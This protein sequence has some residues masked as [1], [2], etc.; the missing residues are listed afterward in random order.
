[1]RRA[2]II[3]YEHADYTYR[4][5]FVFV[6]M[7][8]M[9]VWYVCMVCMCVSMRVCVCVHI[10]VPVHSHNGKLDV[11]THVHSVCILL[12]LH[13]N[14]YTSTCVHMHARHVVN[15]YE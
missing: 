13:T 9:Y 1:M 10:C 3:F 4:Y 7:H 11:E 14:G 2:P 8:G 15:R 12:P 5:V 6:C